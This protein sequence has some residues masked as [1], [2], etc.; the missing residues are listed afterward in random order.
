L[1]SE[2]I[3]DK[4]EDEKSIAVILLPVHTNLL[5]PEQQS[6][7]NVFDAP[8]ISVQDVEAVWQSVC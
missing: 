1:I 2:G 5:S 3:P 6:P 8:F 7:L 4:L